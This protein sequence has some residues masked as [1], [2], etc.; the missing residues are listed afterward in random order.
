M[1]YGMVG[2]SAYTKN[3]HPSTHPGQPP[4]VENLKTCFEKA[5]PATRNPNLDNN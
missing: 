2:H 1:I 5:I 3:L 4:H